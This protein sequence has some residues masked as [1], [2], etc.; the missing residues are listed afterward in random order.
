MSSESEGLSLPHWWRGGQPQLGAGG[1]LTSRQTQV[2]PGLSIAGVSTP[3]E[4]YYRVPRRRQSPAD[5][6][7]HACLLWLGPSATAA[8]F[9]GTGAVDTAPAHKHLS[10]FKSAEVFAGE[11]RE[12]ALTSSRRRPSSRPTKSPA[13]G[14]RYSEGHG[15]GHSTRDRQSKLWREPT[16]WRRP[17]RPGGRKGTVQSRCRCPGWRRTGL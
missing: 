10:G 14:S 2:G 8:P 13:P 3:P 5:D 17:G 9:R 6:T 12:A 16:S 7:P 4:A 11:I 15:I 1:L